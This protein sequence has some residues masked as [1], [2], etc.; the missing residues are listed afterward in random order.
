MSMLI[1]S[2]VAVPILVFFSLMSWLG[3]VIIDPIAAE[4]LNATGGS[5]MAGNA[6]LLVSLVFRFIFP[7]LAVIVVGWWIFGEIRTD[8]RFRRGGFRR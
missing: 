4:T 3:W 7:A 5:T 8:A 2:V 6:L 1:R